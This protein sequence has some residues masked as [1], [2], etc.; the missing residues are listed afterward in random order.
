MGPLAIGA[1]VASSGLQAAGT[2]MAGRERAGAAAFEREQQQRRSEVLQTA[3]A[4]SEARR[5]DELTST[6]Q[7]IMALRAG[8]GGGF[9][10]PSF[11][12]A[13]DKTTEDAERDIRTERLNLLMQSDTARMGAEMLRRRKRF[14]LLSGEIGA[15]GQL[16]GGLTSIARTS[17]GIAETSMGIARTSTRL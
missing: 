16:A 17:M 2:F 13:L 11:N 4:Q 1:T 15:V 6:L 3:A 12:A 9:D 5:R 8:R 10:S 7:T 14:D